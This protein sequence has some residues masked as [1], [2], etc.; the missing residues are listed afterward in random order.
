M[1]VQNKINSIPEGILC[2]N[3]NSI[4]EKV[5]IFDEITNSIRFAVRKEMRRGGFNPLCEQRGFDLADLVIETGL[6]GSDRLVKPLVRD[7]DNQ[8]FYELVGAG[9]NLWDVRKQLKPDEYY[10]AFSE[11]LQGVAA[12]NTL[13]IIHGDF[14]AEQILMDDNGRAKL[15]DYATVRR[16]ED[17]NFF[18]G[19]KEGLV[20]TE[21]F[22]STVHY[23]DKPKWCIDA[24]AVGAVL[25]DIHAGVYKVQNQGD[26]IK[27]EERKFKPIKFGNSKDTELESLISYLVSEDSEQVTAAFACNA[28][29]MVLFGLPPLDFKEKLK[30]ARGHTQK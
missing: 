28:M 21:E 23:F 25:R 30:R 19:H 27:N 2:I 18:P 6:A 7:D 16:F 15:S 3:S 29:R 14:K 8:F 11:A 12:L 26:F 4:V 10:F 24:Y 9:K 13:E 22:L 17:G 5:R 1:K 20:G